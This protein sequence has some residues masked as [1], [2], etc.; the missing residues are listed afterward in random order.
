MDFSF[1]GNVNFNGF[2]PFSK[3][4]WYG[5][6]GISGG[7]YGPSESMNGFFSVNAVTGLILFDWLNISA[8]LQMELVPKFNITVKPMIG[9]VYRFAPTGTVEKPPIKPQSYISREGE[10]LIE[11]TEAIRNSSLISITIP[12]GV[13][14]IGYNAFS[15]CNSLT[16]IT[17]PSSV[18][19]IGDYAFYGCSNLTSIIIPSSVTSIGNY[20]FASCSSLTSITIPSSV[21]SIGEGAFVS[22]SSL[23][24]ITI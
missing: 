9:Y 18:M 11:N 14:S 16:S 13:T 21:T 8:S 24:S 5:G 20:A 7:V 3:G 19:S 6:L 17:I 4:G 12:E 1:N 22:C 2:V 10:T 15:G 23:T